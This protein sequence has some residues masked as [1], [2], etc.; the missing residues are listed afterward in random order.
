M[1]KRTQKPNSRVTEPKSLIFGNNHTHLY[2]MLCQTYSPEIFQ[3]NF[4][5]CYLPVDGLIH[6]ASNYNIHETSPRSY[7]T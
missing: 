6:S 7:S 3:K 4:L 5:K 1:A 2:E